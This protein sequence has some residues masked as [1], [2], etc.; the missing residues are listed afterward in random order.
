M[1]VAYL[2]DE[3]SNTILLPDHLFKDGNKNRGAKKK[4]CRE[5][6]AANVKKIPL[7]EMSSVH[8]LARALNIPHTTVFRMRREE[9]MNQYKSY[10][11]PKL[12]EANIE[13]QLDYAWSQVDQ[14]QVLNT[15]DT[16]GPSVLMCINV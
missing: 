11:K 10:I 14:A 7:K 6:V 4:Y 2:R 15:Y 9:I 16:R 8:D 12:T 1:V 3:V 13:W 5:K